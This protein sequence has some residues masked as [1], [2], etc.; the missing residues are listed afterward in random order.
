MDSVTA[1]SVVLKINAWDISAIVS[2]TTVPTFVTLQRVYTTIFHI[3]LLGSMVENENEKE[4]F[5]MTF[6]NC[7]I[8]VAA[9]LN[10]NLPEAFAQSVAETHLACATPGHS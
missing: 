2:E 6:H 5:T 4:S 3:I 8:N 1:S 7:S 10:G 9:A